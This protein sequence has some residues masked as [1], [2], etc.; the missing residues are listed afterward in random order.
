MGDS[1]LRPARWRPTDAGFFA[2]SPARGDGGGTD[3][4][5][6]ELARTGHAGT[7]VVHIA[8]GVCGMVWLVTLLVSRALSN[9]AASFAAGH[10]EWP[11]A[12]ALA[13]MAAGAAALVGAALI[14][15]ARAG[16][17]VGRVVGT[18]FA[19]VSLFQPVSIL[20]FGDNVFEP[21]KMGD[22]CGYPLVVFALVSP[23]RMAIVVAAAVIGVDGAVTNGADT[24]VVALLS[25]A[26]SW[27]V[28]MPFIV[29]AAFSGH[30][31]R[32]L[33]RHARLAARELAQSESSAAVTRADS[34]FLSFVHDHVLSLLRSL[35]RGTGNPSAAD[36]RAVI[37]SAD[38]QPAARVPVAG[39]V[40]TWVRTV[41]T[42][43]PDTEIDCVVDERVSGCSLPGT[44][45]AVF[46]DALAEAAG[47]SVRHAPG[48]GRRLIVRLEPAA[49]PARDGGAA[50]VVTLQLC[51]D[52]PGFDLHRVSHD[53]AGVRLTILEHSRM[54]PG[55]GATVT[56]RPGD[57][58]T[59]TLVMDPADRAGQVGQAGGAGMFDGP[60][61]IR[62]R[63]GGTQFTH[64]PWT[65]V[66]VA[67]TFTG[68]AIHSSGSVQAVPDVWWAAA[69]AV[70]VGAG[71]VVA[72]STNRL[73][74][75]PT[76]V[77]GTAL[78]V[79]SCCG[80][81]VTDFPPFA[82]PYNWWFQSIQVIGVLM[83]MR[84]R[85]VAALL[86]AIAALQAPTALTLVGLADHGSPP[87][88]LQ[89][90][91][92]I[93]AACLFPLL[94]DQATAALPA[95]EEAMRKKVARLTSSAASSHHVRRV[96]GWLSGLVDQCLDD[97]LDD[98]VRRA[99]AR[100][101]EARL[102]DSIRSPA[103]RDPGLTE[104]VWFARDRGCVVRLLDD[105]SPVVRGPGDT[106]DPRENPQVAELVRTAARAVSGLDRG[107]A[108]IRLM[109]V[110]RR[111]TGSI[112]LAGDGEP[113]LIVVD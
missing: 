103:L 4:L 61:A 72:G 3:P 86:F 107:E 56:T 110:G 101:L 34:L 92:P 74:A 28:S 65:G 35:W 1:R 39:A 58:V 93:I 113:E 32:I 82:W 30:A 8:S 38:H 60:E 10:P 100:L 97:G 19:V 29:V 94:I 77:A 84:R 105:R 50:P 66:G 31:G 22:F 18:L 5:I 85:P 106:D 112:L 76:A 47:N 75:A 111:R 73:A 78:V 27:M 104:A 16:Q 88:A 89:F 59:V 9:V 64:S 52:G 83:G 36:F 51:D 21:L 68:L 24:A 48:A 71:A 33:D 43:A 81:A 109:P 108:T 7:V 45:L 15:G 70:A 80:A 46:A 12:V 99:N 11:S 26:H 17:L 67:A 91:P 57:G 6:G 44:V 79:A 96:Q 14:P 13:A 90:L 37:D 40:D 98:E 95:T 2:E 69:A 42:R 102:R 63:L 62:R 41:R 25:A 87:W 55:C 20:V 23:P 53:R 54:V 49:D